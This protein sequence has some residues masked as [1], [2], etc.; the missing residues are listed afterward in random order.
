MSMTHDME[1]TIKEHL[2]GVSLLQIQWFVLSSLF[3]LS[4][5]SLISY[6][7][8]ANQAAHFIVAYQEGLSGAQAT[9]ANQKYHGH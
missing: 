9:W 4:H 8:F 7:R 1:K 5:H 2:D 3:I 6:L